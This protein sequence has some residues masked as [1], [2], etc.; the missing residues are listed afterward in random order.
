L[1]NDIRFKQFDVPDSCKLNKGKKNENI[2][3]IITDVLDFQL[4]KLNHILDK[5]RMEVYSST[6]QGD[7]LESK[8]IIKI[9]ISED[10][11]EP[12][13]KPKVSFILPDMPYIRE[14]SFKVFA[15]NSF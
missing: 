1:L 14:M 2:E 6:I 13:Y 3:D 15:R 10:N 12:L 8:N 4:D 7:I 9:E 11:F 5:N